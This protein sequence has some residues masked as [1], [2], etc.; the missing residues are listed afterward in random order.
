MSAMVAL[1]EV[2]HY[3]H[4]TSKFLIQL[5]GLNENEVAELLE[6]KLKDSF[7]GMSVIVVVLAY[8]YDEVK[9][10]LDGIAGVD[11]LPTIQVKI[12]PSVIIK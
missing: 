5:K 8:N 12:I 7:D 11:I 10:S 3:I 1:V 4:G 2:K 6:E 9:T